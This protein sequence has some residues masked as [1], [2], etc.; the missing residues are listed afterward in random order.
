MNIEQFAIHL[1]LAE[2]QE[3]QHLD[4]ICDYNSAL[5]IL[6]RTQ[7][8]EQAYAYGFGRGLYDRVAFLAAEHDRFDIVRTAAK[9]TDALRLADQMMLKGFFTAASVCYVQSKQFEKAARASIQGRDYNRAAEIYEYNEQYMEAIM[10]CQKSGNV[11]KMLELQV[12]AF[13]HDLALADGD[14]T[15]VPV[16][17][18]MAIE[19]GKTYLSHQETCQ[20]GLDV[21]EFAGALADVAD[22]YEQS[23][24]ASL[25]A[26]C[27]ARMSDYVRAMRLYDSIEDSSQAIQMAK[28][29]GDRETLMKELIKHRRYLELSKELIALKRYDEALNYLKSIDPSDRIYPDALELQGDVYCRQKHFE[30]ATLCYDTLLYKSLPQERLCRIMYKAAYS[31]EM[32]GLL[33]R[34]LEYY[35]RV[36]DYDPGFH[37]IAEARRHILDRIEDSKR[38]LQTQTMQQQ[39]ATIPVNNQPILGQQA[40]IRRPTTMSVERSRINS[41]IIESSRIPAIGNERYGDLLEVA[42]GG[43]GVVY[44]ATDTILMRTVAL[45]VLSQKLKDND[46]AFEYFMREARASAA[47]QHINIVTVY[48]IGNFQ[49]GTVY[50]AM[51]FVDGK[52][53]KQLVTQTGPFPTRFLVQITIHACRGLQYAHDH[54]IVHRDIKSSNLMLTKKDKT[55]KILD[56]GL[57]KVINELDKG[58]TQAIGTPYYMS[59]EQIQGSEIDNRSDIY[60]LGVTLF[61]LSTGQLPFTKGDLPYKHVHEDPP[62]PSSIN[63]KIN[64]DLEKIILKMLNKAPADRFPSCQAVAQALKAIRFDS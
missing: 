20:K 41:L 61:E 64:P 15:A 11:S 30:D 32:L 31:Y 46:V 63:P 50:L 38:S 48:D 34:A 44:K 16:S 39:H 2:S 1:P 49:D 45:K 24:K 55:L 59:P 60:S 12:S 8:E 36:Y 28:L 25:A 19:A 5:N 35:Q 10:C 51:E 27:A 3:F 9:N 4:A 58:S 13:R 14:L 6:I 42:H 23:G 54:G 22:Q 56:F 33:D 26:M 37:G 43:M 53:L 40:V 7:C 17:R 18:M 47:L 52:T 29:I 21:L 62:A 57:A